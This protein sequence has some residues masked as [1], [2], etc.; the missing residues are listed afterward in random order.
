MKKVCV[1]G[2]GYVGLVTGA[3]LAELGNTV[4]CLDIDHAKIS[5]LQAGVMPIYEPGLDK[6]VSRNVSKG[7]LSFTTS[8]AD[9]VR[10][11]DYCFIAVPTPSEATGGAANMSYVLSAAKS[12]AENATRDLIIVNKSTMPV[13]SGDKVSETARSNLRD[14][15]I[16]VSVVSR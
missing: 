8:Y 12:I 14:G 11:A 15:S 5:Q 6:L 10:D 3:C 13:G 4:I 9:A 1:V 16:T 2:T 7:R